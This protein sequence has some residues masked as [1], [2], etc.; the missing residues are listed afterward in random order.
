VRDGLV[1]LTVHSGPRRCALD[2][3][4]CRLFGSTADEYFSLEDE[5]GS[6]RWL[7]EPQFFETDYLLPARRIMFV[8][9]V[10]AEGEDGVVNF[11]E[12][13]RAVPGF[14]QS[15]LDA[16]QASPAPYYGEWTRRMSDRGFVALK[17]DL[18]E[19]LGNGFTALAQQAATTI[20]AR[21]G[22]VRPDGGVG[23]QPGMLTPSP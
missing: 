18:C 20:A 19:A 7:Q 8:S 23:G 1:V 15:Y 21:L 6:A 17:Y 11:V 3:D 14:S 13:C 22:V 9:I 16:L 4:T 12:R 2:D 5:F 10:T